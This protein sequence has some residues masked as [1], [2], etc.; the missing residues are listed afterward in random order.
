[1]RT[2][3]HGDFHLGQIIVTKT[4]IFIVDFEGEPMRTLAERRGKF[5]PLRDVAGML[6]SFE[7]ASAAAARDCKLA[8][9]ASAPVSDLTKDMQSYFLMAYATAI[10][11][12]V[13]FPK[14]S[15]RQ[16]ICLSFA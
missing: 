8:E 12:C 4:D 13:S 6:R 11:G 14:I 2:R 15:E 10:A 5:L 1:M 7:Y 16:T 9:N 3:L